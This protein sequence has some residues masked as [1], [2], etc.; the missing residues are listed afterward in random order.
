MPKVDE[1]SMHFRVRKNVVQLVRNTYDPASK[2]AVATVVG[3]LALTAPTLTDEIA[4]KLTSDE[5]AEV[6]TWIESQHHVAALQIELAALQL[7]SS[8]ALA[9]QWFEQSQR[10]EAALK[11][12]PQILEAWQRLRTVLKRRRLID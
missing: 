7:P 2:K 6:K 1:T 12:T 3:S 4:S 11:L 10:E 5:L 8:I 9:T